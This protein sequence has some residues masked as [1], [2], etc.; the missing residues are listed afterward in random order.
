MERIFSYGTLQYKKVQKESFGRILKGYKVKL[1]GYKLEEVE[2]KDP[3]VLE[4][5]NQK[6]HPM[7]IKTGNPSDYIEGMIFEITS[8]ELDQ[9][10]KY[11]VD[12]YKRIEETFDDNTKAWI[13]V[14]S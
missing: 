3:K 10:D 5:S 1:I 9:S 14:Q 4:L 13:Y 6:S 7:A 8:D 11:E 2:I 12:D